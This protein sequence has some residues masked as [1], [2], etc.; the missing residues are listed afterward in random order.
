MRPHIYKAHPDE[1]A[2]MDQKLEMLK[3]K[4]E[5]RELESMERKARKKAK[6]KAKAAVTKY[7]REDSRT[8]VI[9]K[10]LAMYIGCTNTPNSIVEN[11]HFKNLLEAL[12]P[13]YPIPGRGGV[14][15]ELNHLLTE[16]KAKIQLYLSFAKKVTLCADIWTKRGL[17]SSYLGVTAHWFSYKDKNR[18]CATLAVELMQGSITGQA[19][20]FALDRILHE[21]D[22]PTEKVCAVIT[23]NGSNMVK[24]FKEIQQEVYHSSED[25]GDSEGGSG[26]LEGGYSEGGELGEDYGDAELEYR[27][28]GTGDYGEGDTSIVED[29]EQEFGDKEVEHAISF[30]GIKRLSCFAHT[31]QL[32]VL[33]FNKDRKIRAVL[34][35]VLSIVR[36]VNS[37]KRATEA[38][39]K[40]SGLKLIGMCPTRWSST[41][42]VIERL[43]KIRP[44]LMKVLAELNW[45][46]IQPSDWSVLNDMNNLLAHFADMTSLCSGEKYVTI[47]SVLPYILLLRRH[48]TLVQDSRSTVSHVA[49]SLVKQLN[50]RF[51]KLF[52]PE[53]EDHE[54][55]YAITTLLDPR[56]KSLIRGDLLQATK[57][58]I[59]KDVRKVCEEES[60][61]ES[62]SD[63]EKSP[64]DPEDDLEPPDKCRRLDS[65]LYN[66][67]V[68]EGQSTAKPVRRGSITAKLEMLLNDYFDETSTPFSSLAADPLDYWVSKL[69]FPLY[70]PLASYAIDNM[71]IP[72]SSAPVERVFSTAGE[73]T[74]G[75]RN[76]LAAKN[77]ETE[78]LLR[79]NCQYI[80][81]DN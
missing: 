76:K 58:V 10:K 25:D 23:D 54:S 11:T 60:D 43:L 48:L 6:K 41:Y 75:R 16:M 40:E 36:K 52:E 13:A 59:L 2:I 19:I 9:T 17:S 62:Q 34:Q 44:H 81:I 24:A 79:R 46:S 51:G 77:L 26:D 80:T 7:G 21:W 18:H 12:D 68:E 31:L 57:N 29:E 70:E 63:Y 4:K 66:L 73:S 30:R 78:V 45:N 55:M 61:L 72:A 20:R 65:E 71:V 27:E 33:N 38:L 5:C 22:I 42:L 32:D 15:T 14:A 64:S 69:S 8:K 49:R 35:R 39:L 1:A 67:I 53:H 3:K 47:S 56:Y 28:G 37:S 74:Q 50:D